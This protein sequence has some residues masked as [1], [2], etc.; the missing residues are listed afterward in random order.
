MITQQ[1]KALYFILYFPQTDSVTGEIMDG[2]LENEINHSSG[3]E[4]IVAWRISVWLKA[5]KLKMSRQEWKQVL[6]ECIWKLF[7]L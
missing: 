4:F 2:C 7:F 1:N 5:S 6:R 3:I